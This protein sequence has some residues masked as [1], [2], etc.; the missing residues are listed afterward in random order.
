MGI[1]DHYLTYVNESEKDEAK[2]VL[3]NRQRSIV[4]DPHK[5]QRVNLRAS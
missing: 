5:L 2:E 3:M 4:G 1:P